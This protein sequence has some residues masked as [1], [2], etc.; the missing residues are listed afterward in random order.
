M[1]SR[2]TKL[3]RKMQI[4]LFPRKTLNIQSP[5]RSVHFGGVISSAFP[6]VTSCLSPVLEGVPANSYDTGLKSLPN[7]DSN[8]CFKVSLKSFL[9][10]LIQGP[11]TLN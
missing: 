6:H 10:N 4:V 3:C 1:D 5:L 9:S 8:V 11:K 7:S 2:S